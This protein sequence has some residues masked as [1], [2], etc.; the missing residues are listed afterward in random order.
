MFID[1]H[2]HLI[3][4]KYDSTENVVARAKE[5]G[6]D[7]IF[8][9]A[10]DLEDSNLAVEL[11][12]KYQCVYACIGLYPE[13]A[14]QYDDKLEKE[15]EKLAKSKKVVALGEI[16]LDYHGENPNKEKQKE[17]DETPNTTIGDLLGN[18]FADYLKGSKK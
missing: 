5:F 7:R 17:A 10:T 1:V 4:E 2:A 16:G 8:C 3:D 15:F 11:S 13:Y 6:V 18:A 14:E 9:A 12:K